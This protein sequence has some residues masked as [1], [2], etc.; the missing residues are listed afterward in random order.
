MLFFV[1][2]LVDDE[3][4]V[5]LNLMEYL[6]TTLLHIKRTSMVLVLDL[7]LRVVLVGLVVLRMLMHILVSGYEIRFISDVV[8]WCLLNHLRGDRWT[9]VLEGRIWLSV[10]AVRSPWLV[11]IALGL[12]RVSWRD[13]FQFLNWVVAMQKRG[14]LRTL[15]GQ[16]NWIRVKVFLRLDS[17]LLVIIQ[18]IGNVVVMMVEIG[19]GIWGVLQVR[20]L[21][22][23][24]L[25]VIVYLL[26]GLRI[27]L[28]LVHLFLINRQ[29]ILIIFRNM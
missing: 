11:V 9:H 5:L 15:F 6:G 10:E 16:I 3:L 25:I 1:A 14:I 13:F 20:Q 23:L 17:V 19:S 4:L 22:D 21:V 27:L 24:A 26:I 8:V 7:V 18:D 12:D 2:H 28:L 29:F